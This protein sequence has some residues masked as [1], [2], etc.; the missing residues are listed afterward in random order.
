MDGANIKAQALPPTRRLIKF[1]SAITVAIVFV[2][3]AVRCWPLW[4]PTSYR[5]HCTTQQQSNLLPLD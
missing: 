2:L 1:H 3:V 4:F 5:T